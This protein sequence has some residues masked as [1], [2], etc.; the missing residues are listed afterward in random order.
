MRGNPK[1]KEIA[2]K[3]LAKKEIANR[4]KKYRRLKNVTQKELACSICVKQQMI[5][6]WESG[7]AIPDAMQLKRIADAL[8]IP[9]NWLYKNEAK[10]EKKNIFIDE[11]KKRRREIEALPETTESEKRA[12]KLARKQFLQYITNNTIHPGKAGRDIRLNELEAGIMT[13]IMQQFPGFPEEYF[14]L[15]IEMFHKKQDNK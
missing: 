5:S 8:N 4:I 11:T 12:K 6:R 14:A 10:P 1:E 3:T 2:E 9:I 7:K 15:G 13:M